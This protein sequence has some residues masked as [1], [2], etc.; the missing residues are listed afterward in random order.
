MLQAGRS[1]VRFPMRWL[2]VFKWPNPSSRTIALESTQLLREICTR[3]LPGGNGGPARKA[4]NLTAICERMWEPRCL[5]TLWAS[6]SCYRDRF[7]IFKNILPSIVRIVKFMTLL[8]PKRQEVEGWWIYF[9]ITG[10]II[11]TFY[12][13]LLEL[14]ND[15]RWG[16]IIRIVHMRMGMS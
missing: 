11:C 3:N 15:G 1:W 16:H 8:G 4:D 5:T 13:I 7:T 2:V 14:S 12:Q 6:T 9:I 10:F